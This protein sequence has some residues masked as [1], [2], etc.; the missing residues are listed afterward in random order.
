MA[1]EKPCVGASITNE[2]DTVLDE[3]EEK[4]NTDVGK[5]L[6]TEDQHNEMVGQINSIRERNNTFKCM[7][8]SIPESSS[9][10]PSEIMGE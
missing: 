5:G 7:L 1:L 4:L 8:Q 6:I 9:V 2:V 10:E 3:S